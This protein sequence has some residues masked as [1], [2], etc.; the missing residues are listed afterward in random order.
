MNVIGAI[1]PRTGRFFAIEA[2][3]SYSLTFQAFLDEAN[4]T[5]NTSRKRNILILDNASWHKLKSPK[6]GLFKPMYLRPYS[7]D[8]NPIERIWLV[9]K[10]NYF[11]SHACKFVDQLMDRLDLA[12]LDIINNPDT[13]KSAAAFGTSF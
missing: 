2:S 4:R 11:N 9:M 10:A 3:H 1:C 13:M 5:V 6:W 12:I 7:P 8:L